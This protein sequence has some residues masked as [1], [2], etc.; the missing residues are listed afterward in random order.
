VHLDFV[1]VALPDMQEVPDGNENIIADL[2]NRSLQSLL[3]E[4]RIPMLK[5]LDMSRMMAAVTV[6][7]CIFDFEPISRHRLSGKPH[8]SLNGLPC[9]AR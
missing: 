1:T 6:N 5:K 7:A 8:Y 2:I 3:D 9:T 4:H